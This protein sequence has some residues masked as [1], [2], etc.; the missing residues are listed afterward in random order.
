MPDLSC[1]C[2]IAH[3]NTGSLTHWVGPGIEPMSSWMLVRLI[4]TVPWWELALWTGADN[5]IH[6]SVV[7]KYLM[8]TLWCAQHF[9]S[10]NGHME[11]SQTLRMGS[12]RGT[13]LCGEGYPQIM[14]L[15]PTV[16]S[17]L[18][19]SPLSAAVSELAHPPPPPAPWAPDWVSNSSRQ[20][21]W[22]QSLGWRQITFNLSN[23]IRSMGQQ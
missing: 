14:P 19:H 1:I 6:Q 3:C 5:L 16:F 9:N 11:D 10:K 22:L 2:T 17:S 7:K 18:A 13:K 12:Y 15:H 20:N 8:E 21:V 23:G 4:S